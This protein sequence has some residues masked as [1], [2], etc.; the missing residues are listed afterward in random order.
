MKKDTHTK[1]MVVLLFLI[2]PIITNGQNSSSFWQEI[3]NETS[4]ASE[5][6][7]RISMPLKHT[8]FN[9]DID[10]LFA[11]LQD[12]PNRKLSKNTSGVIVNFPSIDGGFENYEVYDAPVLGSQL[13]SQLPNVRSFIGKAVKYESKSRRGSSALVGGKAGR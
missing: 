4:F 1:I 7:N 8:T 11:Q 12:A 10:L 13:Q 6:W 9:L 5:K 2:M 3:S